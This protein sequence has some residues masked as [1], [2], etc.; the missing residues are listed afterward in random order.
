MYWPGIDNDI[1]IMISHCVQCQTHLPSHAKE[2]IVSK[3]RPSR[4]FEDIAADFFIMVAS[5]TWL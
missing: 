2:P 3:P 5:V 4:P 1:E